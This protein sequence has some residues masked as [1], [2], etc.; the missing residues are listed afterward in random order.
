MCQGQCD[1]GFVF[2][3][4]FYSERS[5]LRV[6]KIPRSGIPHTS[7]AGCATLLVVFGECKY[8]HA[9]CATP[10]TRETSCHCAGK[11]AATVHHWSSYIYSWSPRVIPSSYIFVCVGVCLFPTTLSCGSPF[12]PSLTVVVVSAGF[13]LS[14]P[15]RA[16]TTGVVVVI[17][18]VFLTPQH[19]QHA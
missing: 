1:L 14:R 2:N 8:E 7:N 13:D 12:L 11:Q 15:P 10:R 17:V 9:G 5:R 3:A 4:K 16:T 6:Y 18:V 19:P